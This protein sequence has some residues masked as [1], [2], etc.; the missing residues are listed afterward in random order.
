MTHRAGQQGAGSGHSRRPPA[1]GGERRAAGSR[2]GRRRPRPA[3]I[4]LAL[5]LAAGLTA[6][7]TALVKAGGAA[8]VSL[9]TVRA[10]QQSASAVSRGAFTTAH[11]GV[12]EALEDYFDDYPTPAQPIA[13]NHKI[14][15]AKGLKCLSCHAAAA[16]GPQAGIPS[17]TFCMACHQVIAT[18]NPEIQKLAAYAA[19]GQDVPWQPVNW[20]YPSAHVRFWHAPHL[21]AGVDCATCHGDIGQETVAVRKSGLNMHFCLSCHREKGVSVDCTTCHD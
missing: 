5:F 10:S 6:L 18:N 7:A 17:V 8:W 9:S 4:F 3:T 2:G 19:K 11:P 1:T 12:F 20:F 15:I 16:Q 13:F 14:H 21:R